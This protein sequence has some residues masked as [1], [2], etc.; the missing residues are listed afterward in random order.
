MKLKPLVNLF[1]VLSL[2]ACSGLPEQTFNTDLRNQTCCSTFE[3]LPLT[4]L[5]TPFHQQMVIDANFPTLNSTILF[6][7]EPSPSQA[8][9]VIGYQVTSN[10]PFSL[11]VR[12]YIVNNQLFAANILVYNENWQLLSNCSARDFEYHTTNMRGLERIEQVIAINPQLNGAKYIVIT[13]DP[14]LLG[15]K[16]TRKHP[17]EVYAESQ[18][19]IGNKL[20]PLYAEFQYLGVMDVITS[21]STNNGVLTLLAELSSRSSATQK[22]DLLSST[23]SAPLDE[24]ALYQSQID[25]ALINNDIKEAA[26]I[27][28]EIAEK[29]F[30]QSK[31][32]LVEQL[33]K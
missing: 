17:E 30:I 20:L 33:A 26:A 10:T 1:M 16:L 29:G 23:S 9:P 22:A 8:L 32:Y 5:S 3:T 7:S 18:N 28:N 21:S 6:T 27:A 14:T 13:S 25:A 15:S 2:S 12:S 4:T 19:V 31:N 24:W 11:F